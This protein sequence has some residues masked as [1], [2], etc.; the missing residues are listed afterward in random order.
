MRSEH[1]TNLFQT[2]F[3]RCKVRKDESVV[4]LSSDRSR[5]EYVGAALQAMRNIG[6]QVIQLHVPARSQARGEGK[7]PIV[8]LTPIS[9][10]RAAIEALKNADFVVDLI[11]LIHSLEQVEILKAGTRML[12][13]IEPPEILERLMPTGEMRS[14]IEAGAAKLKAAKTLRVLSDVGTDVEMK[15]GQYPVITQYGLTDTPG[16][17]DH[18][19]SSFLYTWPNEGGTNGRVVLN[20]RDFLWPWN[21]YLN[22]AISLEIEN[23]YIRS[24]KGGKEADQFRS[25]LESYKD[26]EAFAVSHIGWGVDPRAKWD[27]LLSQ[28]D[29]VGMDPRSYVGN[30]LFST[31]PN[32]EAGGTRHTLAH[33]DMPMLGCTLLLDGKPVVKD[34]KLVS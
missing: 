30:V 22:E 9:G 4:V 2:E 25:E 11:L 28:P 10:N 31:G 29:S 32:T 12:L 7:E 14:A 5:P 33:F 13:V 6:A 21:I 34:G 24:I 17:W 3:E 23:G 27:A 15:L 26:P 16:R 18:W 19:P 8:G 20:K 1:L